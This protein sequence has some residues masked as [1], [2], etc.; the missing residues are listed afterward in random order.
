MNHQAHSDHGTVLQEDQSALVLDPDGS[1]RLLLP[2]LPGDA[3]VNLGHKLVVAIALRL[4][5]PEWI[6]EML[7]VLD[8]AHQDFKEH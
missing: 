3:P 4:Y 2:D 5:D 6:E 7:G 1:F 8:A